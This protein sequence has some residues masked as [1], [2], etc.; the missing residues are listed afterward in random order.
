MCILDT[1]VVNLRQGVIL[2]NWVMLYKRHNLTI[3]CESILIM[4]ILVSPFKTL[5]I[6]HF[7]VNEI[8][9]FNG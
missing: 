4:E 9:N 6:D 5:S 7:R 1:N 2:D 8:I 3:N